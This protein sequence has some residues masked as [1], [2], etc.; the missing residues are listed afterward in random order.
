MGA[1]IDGSDGRVLNPADENL[2]KSPTDPKLY[3][4]DVIMDRPFDDIIEDAWFASRMR[5]IT[6]TD[7]VNFASLTADWHPAHTNQQWA[8]DNVFGERIAHGMLLLS[9]SIGLVPNAYVIALRKVKNVVYKTPVRF[10]D[11]VHVRGRLEKLQPFN[12]EMGL[13]SAR[14]KLVNQDLETCVKME[15]E[16]LW[17]RGAIT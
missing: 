10:G 8:E 4:A 13:V 15:F 6:E 12:D 1:T 14:W 7:V 16:M 3:R 2:P 11:T 17:K 5:T 9:Y